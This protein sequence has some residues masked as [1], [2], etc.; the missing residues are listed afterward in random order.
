[1]ESLAL[2]SPSLDVSAH[3]VRLL[4]GHYAG[5]IEYRT[6]AL[7]DGGTTT[8]VESF[9]AGVYDTRRE[10]QIAAQRLMTTFVTSVLPSDQL[11]A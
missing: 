6:P 9:F 2:I 5:Y 7:V 10:A 11:A 8:L 3:V 1:M 4:H